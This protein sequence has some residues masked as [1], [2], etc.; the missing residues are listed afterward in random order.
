MP[1]PILPL[2]PRS[3]NKG[4]MPRRRANGAARIKAPARQAG[5]SMVADA[6]RRRAQSQGSVTPREIRAE[7]ARA[8]LAESRWKEVVSQAGAALTCRR[9]RYYYVPAGPS[10][11]RTRVRHDHRQ[12]QHLAAAVRFLIRQQRALEAV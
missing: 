7:L 2:S 12:H 6:V 3:R 10:R 1:G 11:M 5:L 4:A 8:G 9:G